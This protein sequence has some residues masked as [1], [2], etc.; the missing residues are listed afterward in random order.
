[1]F[2][3]ILAARVAHRC[4]NPD[5]GAVTSGPKEQSHEAV[6]VGV[7]AHIT[8]AALGGPRYD[9]TLT[10]SQRSEPDNGIWLCVSCA[11]LVDSDLPQYTVVILRHWMERGGRGASCIHAVSAFGI[12]GYAS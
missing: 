2:K 7:A 9:A 6:N 8:A 10:H 12:V 1:V 3:D 11:K 4:S 5:C